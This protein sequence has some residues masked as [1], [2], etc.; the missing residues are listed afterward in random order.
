MGIRLFLAKYGKAL[1]AATLLLLLVLSIS[2]LIYAPSRKVLMWIVFCFIT[3]GWA[4]KAVSR[5]V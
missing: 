4:W 1:F 2:M 3:L 5:N